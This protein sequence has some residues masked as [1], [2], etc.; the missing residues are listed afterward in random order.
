MRTGEKAI[1]G[2]IGLMVISSISYKA[3]HFST[4]SDEDVDPGIPYYS[5]ASPE[6][7]DKAGRLI[8][9]HGCK[10]CHKL[11]FL[12]NITQNVPAPS[13]DGI[14]SLKS[15]E[16][17]YNYF[18]VENPQQIIPSR[19]KARFQM[20]SYAHLPEASRRTLAAYMASLKVE[21]WYLEETKKAAYEKLTGKDYKPE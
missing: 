17:F 3:W 5:T 18:S 19:L 16:W 4:K 21:D 20:P 1:Y 2:L 7:R 9:E 10:D 13:L 8:R 6:L 11:F 14:G 12:N 15:E